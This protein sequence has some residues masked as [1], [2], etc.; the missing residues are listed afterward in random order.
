MSG[1]TVSPKNPTVNRKRGRNVKREHDN[2]RH[3]LPSEE[4][5]LAADIVRPGLSRDLLLRHARGWEALEKAGVMLVRQRLFCVIVCSKHD[6]ETTIKLINE[7]HEEMRDAILVTA[8]EA[9][10]L[11]CAEGRGTHYVIEI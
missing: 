8:P 11:A 5:R 3:A 2:A 6:A 4:F 9:A 10:P 7:K 1:Q